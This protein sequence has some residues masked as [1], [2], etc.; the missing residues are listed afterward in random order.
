MI[1]LS[2]RPPILCSAG[3]MAAPA[4]SHLGVGPNYRIMWGSLEKQNQ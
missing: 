2:C 3:L 4:H 1:S